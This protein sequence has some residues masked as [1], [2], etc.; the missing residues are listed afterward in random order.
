M[1]KKVRVLVKQYYNFFP[2]SFIKLI[3]VGEVSGT[4]EDNLLYLNEHY[5]QQ[6]DEI[7]DN[8]A[9][10]IEPILLILIG[11]V[12]GLLTITMITPLYQFVSSINA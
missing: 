3:E 10:F 2:I 8:F 12:I 7:S 1:R 9:T 6:V 4:L 5:S 11:V